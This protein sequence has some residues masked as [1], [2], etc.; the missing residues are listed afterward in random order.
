MV[1]PFIES[2][3]KNMFDRRRKKEITRIDQDFE[4]GET[5]IRMENITKRFPGVLANDRIDLDIKAGEIHALL[6]ENGAGKSTLMRILYGEHKPDEGSIYFRGEEINIESPRHAID[7]GIGMV[8]QHFRLIPKLTV[9]ENILLGIDSPNEPFLD[10]NW[11]KDKIRD[12][13]REYGFKI[14]LDSKIWQLSVGEKQIVEILKVL[15]QGSEIIILDEPTA[16][17]TPKEKEKLLNSIV[18]M[19]EDNLAVIPFVTHKLPEVMRISDRVTI[20]RKGKKIDTVNTSDISQRELAKKMVGREVLF[21]IQKKPIEKGNE[22]LKVDGL[23]VLGDKGQ[24]ALRDISFKIREGEILGIA[25]VSG[26]GQ[27]ELA[28]AITGL[29]KTLDGNIF[30][31]N[32]DITKSSTRDRRNMKM[33]FIPEDRMTGLIMERSLPENVILGKHSDPPYACHWTLPFDNKLFVNEDKAME[34]CQELLS[35]YDVDVS[36]LHMKASKLSGGNMQRIILA[37][38]LSRKPD[39]LLVD[40]PTRGLD[41]GSAEYVRRKLLS[42]RERGK[43][44]LLISEDLDE[45][46]ML[47]DSIIVIYEGEIVDCLESDKASKEDIGRMMAGESKS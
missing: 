32:K 31:K 45:I 3:R 14:D 36:D 11:A 42:E 29:R 12:I 44:I 39:F 15:F 20:L 27:K 5:I 1:I 30:Y 37:R 18:K 46:M 6:G 40:K 22:I 7:L 26:N 34:H 17:L 23:K 16:V 10:I 2:I 13:S 19:A 33:G 8:Y 35:E 47:S 24:V 41:V 43:G 21:Q 9:T 38:E 28:E 25:G 4:P